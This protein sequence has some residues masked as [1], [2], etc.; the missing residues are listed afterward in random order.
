MGEYEYG[1]HKRAPIYSISCRASDF[2]KDLL[3][4]THKDLVNELDE[5]WGLALWMFD[6]GSRHK[7]K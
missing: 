2:G 5:L 4:Y 3:N 7:K 6:D 1:V